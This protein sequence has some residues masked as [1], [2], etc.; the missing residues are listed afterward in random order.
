ML[1]EVLFGPED[2]GSL[3]ECEVPEGLREI[4]NT[5]VIRLGRACKVVVGQR[6]DHHHRRRR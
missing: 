1:V 6:L 3:D 2:Q 4:E 5:E